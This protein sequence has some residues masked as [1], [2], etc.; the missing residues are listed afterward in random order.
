[1][2]QPTMLSREEM[3]KGH[4]DQVMQHTSNFPPRTF[5]ELTEVQ[6]SVD[7][8]QDIAGGPRAEES[9]L[10]VEGDGGDGDGSDSNVGPREARTVRGKGS[11]TR[12]RC[13]RKWMRASGR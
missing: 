8:A 13:R 4:V 3:C 6:T 7:V 12:R 11:E 1:M 9:H 2:E 10:F 5:S